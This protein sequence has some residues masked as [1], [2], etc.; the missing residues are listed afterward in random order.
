[1]EACSCVSLFTLA[2]S[3]LS[4]RVVVLPTVGSCGTTLGPV[5][6]LILYYINTKS[7]DVFDEEVTFVVSNIFSLPLSLRVGSCFNN[8]EEVQASSQG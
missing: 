5:I 8:E 7:R 4:F 2:C 1:M 3:L 6:F